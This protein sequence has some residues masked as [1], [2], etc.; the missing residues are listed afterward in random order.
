MYILYMVWNRVHCVP[1]EYLKLK[2]NINK[3]FAEHTKTTFF[4]R[5]TCHVCYWDNFLF[6]PLWAHN[7]HVMFSHVFVLMTCSYHMSPVVGVLCH[8]SAVHPGTWR[9]HTSSSLNVAFMSYFTKRTL[10]VVWLDSH[11]CIA[12]FTSVSSTSASHDDNV[13]YCSRVDSH[14]TVITRVIYLQNLW[15]TADFISSK[16][17]QRQWFRA[18]ISIMITEARLFTISV[19]IVI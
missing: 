6:C 19:L 16:Y 10:V 9:P 18:I 4:Y 13:E 1:L 12:Y 17:E 3:S 15:F 2:Q 8:C 7:D 5:D 11:I 14:A